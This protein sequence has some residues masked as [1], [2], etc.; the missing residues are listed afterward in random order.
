MK[1]TLQLD[2]GAQRRKVRL[3]VLLLETSHV[4]CGNDNFSRPPDEL[5]PSQVRTEGHGGLCRLF[6]LL[7]KSPLMVSRASAFASGH[8]PVNNT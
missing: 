8:F 5:R 7:Y 4:D 1:D 3:T 2:S 6:S